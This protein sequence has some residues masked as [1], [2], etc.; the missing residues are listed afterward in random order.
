MKTFLEFLE[1]QN[2]YHGGKRLVSKPRLD[3][4][5]QR[6]RGFYGKGFYTTPNPKHAAMYGSKISKYEISPD[7]K[8]LQTALNPKDAHADHVEDV[9]KWHDSTGREAAKA[10]GKEKDFDAEL[11]QIR[12]NHISWHNAV[13]KYATHHG[14]DVVHYSD[15]FDNGETVVKN[16]KAIKYLG[17]HKV[18]K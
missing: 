17:R 5:Q 12:T 18:E 13:D 7:A 15:R 16:P 1:E 4:T 14:Y 6:D 8:V 10:K 3:L 11:N 9:V 2:L